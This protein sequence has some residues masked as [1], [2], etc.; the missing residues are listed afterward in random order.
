MEA[1]F[2]GGILNRF[3]IE[4]LVDPF[5]Q[6]HLPDALQVAG[7]RAVGQAIEGMQDG[8]VDGKFRDGQPFENRVLFRLFLRPR[9]GLQVD[10]KRQKR[11]N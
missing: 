1:S 10:A 9:K 6:A 5:G 11:A 3:G 4:L 7:T 8:L 2:D